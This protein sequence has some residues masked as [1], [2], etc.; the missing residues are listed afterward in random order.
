MLGSPAGYGQSEVCRAFVGRGLGMNIT[1]PPL[2]PVSACRPAGR[3]LRAV[4]SG[5]VPLK[6]FPQTAARNRFDSIRF[7]FGLFENSSLRFGS[8]RFV[9]VSQFDAVRPAFFGHVVARSGS[10]RFGSVRFRVRFRPVPEF[11][12]SAR[13]GRAGS[14][15]FRIPSCL[16]AISAQGASPFQGCWMGSGCVAP[17][18]PVADDGKV[19]SSRSIAII[20][21]ITIIIINIITMIII[22]IIIVISV[23]ADDGKAHCSK[24]SEP[25]FLGLV[26][27]TR[28]WFLRF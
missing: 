8:V 17:A 9:S 26:F 6:G 7:G 19:L 15:R 20:V 18:P 28:G 2:R 21:I 25:I 3:L 1:A 24:S 14:A 10:V 12:G 5:C 4:D 11:N 27:E 16:T 13:F 22:T 23:T